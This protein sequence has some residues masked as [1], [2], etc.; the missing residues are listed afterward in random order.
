MSYDDVS[1]LNGDIFVSKDS[2][3][4]HTA[5]LVGSKILEIYPNY[6]IR[7]RSH[8]GFLQFIL[9]IG[10]KNFRLLIICLDTKM[11]VY[12]RIL[13]SVYMLLQPILFMLLMHYIFEELLVNYISNNYKFGWF[14]CILALFTLLLVFFIA[15]KTV[16]YIN[17]IALVMLNILAYLTASNLKEYLPDWGLFWEMFSVSDCL[18]LSCMVLFLTQ[19]LARILS[20]CICFYKS[21]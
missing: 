14:G 15:F 17:L 6:G 16:K 5:M 2:I 12:R 21:H 9:K 1:Y 19:I 8:N 4:G 20:L 11:L 13:I 10:L 3:T 7:Y 18:T